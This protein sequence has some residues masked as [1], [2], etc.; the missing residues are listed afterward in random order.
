MPHLVQMDKRY[1]DKGL[2]VIAPEV[3]GSQ[4]GDIER[5]IN[6]AGAEFAVTTGTTRPPTLQGIPHAVIFDP[7]GTLVFAGHPMDDEFDRTVKKALRD[8]DLEG[9]ESEE[10][11]LPAAPKEL[12][13]SR[14]WTNED[15]REIKAAVLSADAGVVRFKLAS[16]KETDYPISKLSSHDQLLIKET[17]E[18]AAKE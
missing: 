1:K 6:D 16:G 17:L 11:S 15:G 18:S 2:V 10:S 13:E 3:Q 9:E 7:S 5:V 8:V 14:M 12:I 4:K